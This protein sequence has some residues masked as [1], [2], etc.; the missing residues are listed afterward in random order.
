MKVKEETEKVGI[1]L[2]IKKTKIVASG[3]ITTWQIDGETMETVTDYFVGLQNHCR[4]WLQPWNWKILAS[5]QKSYDKLRQ[6]TKTQRH[7]FT[8]KGLSSQSYGFSRSHVQMWELDYKK[9]WAPKNWCVWTV[10]LES[11]FESPLDCKEIQP[12]HPKG[13]QSWEF[14]GRTDVETE[15]PIL[16]PPY[17]NSWLIW[18]YPDAGKDWRWEEKGTTEDEKVG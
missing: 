1:K 11:T 4:W 16:W 9:S 17:V 3:F 8:N 15:T 13:D 12:V 18:K 2:N 7:Y 6:H 5:W 10:M 14:I